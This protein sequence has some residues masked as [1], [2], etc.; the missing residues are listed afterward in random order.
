VVFLAALAGLGDWLWSIY[1]NTFPD[2]TARDS[3]TDSTFLLPFIVQNKSTVFDMKNVE[4]TCGVGAFILG[5][6]KQT[7][8]MVAGLQ[9]S[10]TNA[11]ILAGHPANFPCDAS[12]LVKFEGVKGIDIM[13]LH[14][15]LPGVE[16]MKVKAISTTITVRYRTLGWTRTYHSDPFDWLCTP[17]GCHWTK[18]PTI[19]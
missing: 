9:S 13:G 3:E 17:Q 18:G 11:I 10:Q 5:N 16:P 2:V 7:M 15:D 4:L 12:Q 1:Q 14:A 6:G 19:H 8:A